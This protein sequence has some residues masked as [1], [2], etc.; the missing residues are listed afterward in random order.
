M[1]GKEQWWCRWEEGSCGWVDLMEI[2]FVYLHFDL[3]EQNKSVY[4]SFVLLSSLEA[5]TFHTAIPRDCSCRILAFAECSAITD[6]YI[7]C[8]FSVSVF[9]LF[10][11]FL[12]KRREEKGH[13][14][15][16]NEA[17]SSCSWCWVCCE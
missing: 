16:E 1:G 14:N 15:V 17:N 6:S 10:S 9:F 12:K 13:G 4:L 11:F 8:C 3:S 2:Y 5:R 7:F